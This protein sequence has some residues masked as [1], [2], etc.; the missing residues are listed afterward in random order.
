MEEAR[1][2]GRLLSIDAFRVVCALAVYLFHSNIQLGVDYGFLNGFVG[3]AHV[4]MVAFF[5]LSGFCLYYVDWTRGRFAEGAGL[6]DVR[7]FL[8]RRLLAIYP[9]Y[10]AVYVLYL[11]DGFAAGRIPGMRAEGAVGLL[12]NVVAAPV[13]LPMLQSVFVGSFSFLHNGGTWFVSCIFLCYLFYPYVSAVAA[14]NSRRNNLLLAGALY[15]VSSYAFLPAYR[16]GFAEIYANPLLR[17]AEFSAGVVVGKLF[18]D[19][20]GREIPKNRRWIVFACALALPLGIELWVRNLRSCVEL[21]NFAAVPCFGTVLYLCARL[22]TRHGAGR[23]GKTVSV[24]AENAYAF[25][26]AQFFSWRPVEFLEAN[27]DLLDGC[28]DFPRLAISTVWTCA[29]AAALHYGIEKPCR[30]FFGVRKAA[31]AAAR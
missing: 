22:E 29:L 30:R 18:V 13:E 1:K 31:R 7:G 23:C 28:G 12:D 3:K 19:D 6:G 15:C 25:F 26:L 4:F 2:Q 9:L 8:K 10:V 16:F 5:M 24:L 14:G 21:F 20:S 17:L 11:L 27:T